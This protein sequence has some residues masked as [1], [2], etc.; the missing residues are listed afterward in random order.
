[1]ASNTS[2]RETS[3]TSG[4]FKFFMLLV[5]AA[6]AI[7]GYMLLSNM[8]VC[9]NDTSIVIPDSDSSADRS[10]SVSD[11]FALSYNGS[12][13]CSVE[14]MMYRALGDFQGLF[15]EN[16]YEYE[17]YKNGSVIIGCSL[18]D[19]TVEIPSELGG[20]PVV[21]IGEFGMYEYSELS[22][23]SKRTA[24]KGNSFI[25]KLVV[26]D[27]VVVTG[28]MCFAEM[29]CLEELVLP[30]SLKYYMSSAIGTPWFGSLS[31]EFCIVGDGI[32]IK[33][34]GLGGDVAIPEGVRVISPWAM[35]SNP[36]YLMSVPEI[37]TISFPSTLTYISSNAVEMGASVLSLTIPDSVRFID[38][39]AIDL[40][41]S[42]YTIAVLDIGSGVR[43]ATEH[44]FGFESVWPTSIASLNEDFVVVGDG[45]LIR[46]NAENVTELPSGI[47]SVNCSLGKVSNLKIPANVQ[48]IG[49]N[50]L[51]SATEVVLSEGLQMVGVMAFN[52]SRISTLSLPS[53]V[54]YLGLGSF[55]NCTSLTSADL[56]NVEIIS[57]MAFFNNAVLGNV[58]LGREVSYIGKQA[59]ALSGISELVLPENVRLI[60]NETFY[61]CSFLERVQVCSMDTALG[62]SIFF[63][64]DSAVLYCPKGSKTHTQA[65]SGN[66]KYIAE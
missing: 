51:S 6:I 16:G 52:N 15:N 33:Y 43:F 57:P 58:S 12:V 50:A 3:T 36:L 10:E 5:F 29:A 62:D 25:K 23:T 40:S 63:G 37:N 45:V 66:I 55:A 27:S 4:G 24:F 1:M 47:R 53:S 44:S 59:F 48:Y 64:S 17:L 19:E 7:G 34:N 22:F 26:P 61:G 38:D 31:D 14:E 28:S 46:C 60:D 13:T 49:T 2:N 32:L 39:Y 11:G 9:E 54:W 21:C 18:T 8:S 56:K 35:A 20:K 42:A 41:A 30:K 65:A